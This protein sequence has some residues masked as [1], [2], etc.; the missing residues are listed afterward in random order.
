MCLRVCPLNVTRWPM[1]VCLRP[2]RQP[3]GKAAGGV[4]NDLTNS[5]SLGRFVWLMLVLHHGSSLIMEISNQTDTCHRFLRL[6]SVDDRSGAT[7]QIWRN[8]SKFGYQCNESK[9]KSMSSYI[10]LYNCKGYTQW[11]LHILLTILCIFL[12]LLPLRIGGLR[13]KH[14]IKRPNIFY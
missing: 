12:F 11:N 4:G 7:A 6:Y 2:V 1:L 3:F 8:E 10:P 14:V 9:H 13:V 5:K